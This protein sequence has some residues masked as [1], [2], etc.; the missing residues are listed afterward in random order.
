MPIKIYTY[1]VAPFDGTF[2]IKSDSDIGYTWYRKTYI[3]IWDVNG[4]PL[5]EEN[6]YEKNEIELTLK[7]GQQAKIMM[8]CQGK[9]FGGMNCYFDVDSRLFNYEEKPRTSYCG[10]PDMIKNDN[11][12]STDYSQ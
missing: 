2:T 9:F 12:I 5:A 11:S 10:A 3:S 7:E 8:G 4:Q 1:V 6:G